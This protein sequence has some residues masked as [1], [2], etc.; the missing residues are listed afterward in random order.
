MSS[1]V[2]RDVTNGWLAQRGDWR[3]TLGV[4]QSALAR[5]NYV[6][7]T[8]TQLIVHCHFVPH[9]DQGMMARI[10]LVPP[11]VQLN[12]ASIVPNETVPTFE[13]R[14]STESISFEDCPFG[15]HAVACIN[16]EDIETKI[17]IIV[18]VTWNYTSSTCNLHLVQGAQLRHGTPQNFWYAFGFGGSTYKTVC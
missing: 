2:Q 16:V 7:Y 3:D 8:N 15:R 9:E 14:G 13:Q 6:D 18:I 4:S 11:S 12:N 5:V 17:V 10:G 1:F